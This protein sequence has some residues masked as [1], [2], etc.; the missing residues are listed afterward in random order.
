MTETTQQ[1]GST[2]LPAPILFLAGLSQ[3]ILGF[4]LAAIGGVLR[5]FPI[6]SII[7]SPLVKAAYTLCYNGG[8]DTV[9]GLMGTFKLIGRG[10]SFGARSGAKAISERRGR[11]RM[12]PAK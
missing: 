8:A 6:T 12:P 11:S 4:L 7:G 10:I 1:T 9:Q 3:W 2:T 5:A